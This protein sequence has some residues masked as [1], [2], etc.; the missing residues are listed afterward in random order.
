M[1]EKLYLIEG[2][3]KRLA[4]KH[5]CICCG[6]DFLRRKTVANNRKKTECCSA[7]C[8]SKN[9]KHTIEVECFNCGKNVWKTPS[10]IKAAK[11]NVYFCSRKC[12]DVAQSLDGGCEAIRPGH[13]G[14]GMASYRSIA[15]RSSKWECRCGVKYD[16]IL[17]VHHKDG[18]RE[19]NTASNLEV[20]CPLCHYIRH[21]DKLENGEWAMRN[22]VLTPREKIPEIEKLI[23]GRE[24]NKGD[25]A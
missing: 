9:R 23:F 2:G 16:G 7:K 6:N 14:N 21:M 25:I 19:N 22:T 17:S 12:K 15:K 24:I 3:R 10:K 18:N 20:V 13:Y 5:I 4:E 11:H 1:N 8:A